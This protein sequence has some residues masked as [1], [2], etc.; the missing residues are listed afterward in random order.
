M[1]PIKLNVNT[2]SENYPIIIGSNLIKNLGLYFERNSIT[3]NQC[4]L[5]IDKNVPSKLISRI[6]KSL[7]KNEL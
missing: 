3:F 6:T 4:L 1:K 7:N 2:G 5:I